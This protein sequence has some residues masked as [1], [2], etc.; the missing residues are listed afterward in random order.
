MI[1]H[2]KTAK[3]RRQKR[4]RRTLKAISSHPRL[5]VFRSSKNIYAQVIDD[6]KGITVA[7]VSSK[8]IK[9][10]GTKSEMAQKVGELVA[11]KALKA[12]IIK[13]A[14]DRGSYKYHGRV[15]AIAEGARSQ[16]LKV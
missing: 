16:G 3:I 11:Q 4:T 7:A 9:S 15:K 10:T 5:S 12:K 2:Y 13:V 1:T 14:F 6:Q 8:D